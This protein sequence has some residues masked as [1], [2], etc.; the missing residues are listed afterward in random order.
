MYTLS[1]QK[2]NRKQ[3]AKKKHIFLS[4]WLKV[5]DTRKVKKRLKVADIRKVKKS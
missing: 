2:K 1:H 5:A 3:E 4:H